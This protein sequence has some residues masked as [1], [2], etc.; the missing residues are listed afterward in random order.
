[1]V[2]AGS[3]GILAIFRFMVFFSPPDSCLDGTSIRSWPRPT[4]FFQIYN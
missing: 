3:L 2:L 4:K 1:M